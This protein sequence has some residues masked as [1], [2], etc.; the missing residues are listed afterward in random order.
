MSSTGY[1]HT[2]GNEG[3]CRFVLTFGVFSTPNL[4]FTT[5]VSFVLVFFEIG[6]ILLVTDPF[7]FR[8]ECGP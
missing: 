8:S 7:V 5:T 1:L 3:S 6:R 2:K 4:A